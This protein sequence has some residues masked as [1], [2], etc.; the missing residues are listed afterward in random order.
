MARTYTVR[1]GVRRGGNI[2]PMQTVLE[3]ERLA[4]AGATLREVARTL[5]ISPN[6]ATKYFPHDAKC[7]CGRLTLE[8]KGWCSARFAKSEA[9]KAVLA[10][11]HKKRAAGK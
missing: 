4:Y 2:T 9:R 7:A 8:H 10:R 1:L 6:T 3:I 11:L 5:D